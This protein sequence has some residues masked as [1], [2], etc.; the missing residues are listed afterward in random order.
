MPSTEK[1]HEPWNSFLHDLDGV[2]TGVTEV[3]C[4]GGFVLAEPTV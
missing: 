1:L 4:F 2:L 3:H